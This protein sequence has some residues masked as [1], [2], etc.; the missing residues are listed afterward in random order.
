MVLVGVPSRAGSKTWFQ[1]LLSN[2]FRASRNGGDGACIT[3]N[4]RQERIKRS[5]HLPYKPNESTFARIFLFLERRGF[6]HSR[7]LFRL[8]N[9]NKVIVVRYVLSAFR[10][11]FILGACMRTLTET[12][13]P[14][15]LKPPAEKAVLKIA[16]YAQRLTQGYSVYGGS[17]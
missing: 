7:A 2:V 4:C 9:Q 3:F 16:R 12:D 8:P 10:R 1:S 14:G 5:L 17:S 13:F 6:S 11:H 15:K